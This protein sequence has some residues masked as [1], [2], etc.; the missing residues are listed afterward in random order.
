MSRRLA[1]VCLLVLAV[2]LV[3][4]CSAVRGSGK[5]VT[6][7]RQVGNVD[8]VDV[9]GIGRLE[10]T[11]GSPAQLTVEADDNLMRY[12]KTETQGNQLI[13]KTEGL[14]IPFVLLQPSSTIVYHLRMPDPRQLS[15]GGSGEIV[16]SDLNVSKLG[17]DI[18]GSGKASLTNLKADQFSYQL[19]GSGNADITGEVGTEDVSV[20]GSGRLT[21]GDLK[22]KT[23]S[24]TISGSG[25]AT[26]WATDALDVTISGSGSVK[27]Y[28][29]PS[30]SQHVSGSGSLRSLGSKP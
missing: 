18:S 30:V 22:A 3:S 10:V 14:A 8:S 6:E 16:A 27:Y 13:I 4:A 5:V 19:S 20:S 1:V 2:V 9:Q 12:I 25:D 17:V 28:G 11:Q 21:A 29:S 7:Q 26:V 15:L 24:V 23:V